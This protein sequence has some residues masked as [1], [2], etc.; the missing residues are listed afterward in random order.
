VGQFKFSSLLQ[1]LSATKKSCF[2]VSSML[3]VDAYVLAV[4]FLSLPFTL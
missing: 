3:L 2:L 4:Y 1:M